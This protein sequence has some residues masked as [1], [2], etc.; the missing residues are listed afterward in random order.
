MVVTMFDK[1]SKAFELSKALPFSAFVSLV[2]TTFC[3]Q[4]SIVCLCQQ[5]IY[6]SMQNS[7]T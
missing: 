5:S 7:Y 1:L 4:L 3:I 2:V 6:P